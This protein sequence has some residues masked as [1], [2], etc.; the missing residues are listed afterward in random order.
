MNLARFFFRP[1]LVWAERSGLFVARQYASALDRLRGSGLSG[2][3]K[4]WHAGEHVPHT[5]G[6]FRYLPRYSKKEKGREKNQAE[7]AGG[8]QTPTDTQRVAQHS[9]QGESYL[10]FPVWPLLLVVHRER[11]TLAL[12]PCQYY[13]L[14]GRWMQANRGKKTDLGVHC[15]IQWHLDIKALPVP[16]KKNYS[17]Y[18][19]FSN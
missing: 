11:W 17:I 6:M 15:R 9:A 4:T 7:K 16:E 8:F 13:L 12:G 5:L 1:V 19:E 2:K 10:V 18:Q 3:R 14:M